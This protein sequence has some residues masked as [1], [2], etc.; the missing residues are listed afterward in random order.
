MTST[1]T[2]H[3]GLS[4]RLATDL[5]GR[6]LVQTRAFLEM[7]GLSVSDK[8]LDFYIAG[9]T[10]L[11]DDLIGDSREMEDETAVEQERAHQ[12]AVQRMWCAERGCK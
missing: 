7:N 11:T 2:S 8:Y 6:L 9:I 4:A 10:D 1:I 5:R 12:A 3:T